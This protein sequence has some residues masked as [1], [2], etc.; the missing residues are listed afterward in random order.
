VIDPNLMGWKLMSGNV[1]E[2]FAQVL[3]L[4]RL[5]EIADVSTVPQI[6]TKHLASLRLPLPPV[7][8]QHAIV[9]ALAERC[10]KIDVLVAKANEVVATLREY[11]AALITDA[12]TGKIDVRAA[13]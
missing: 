12:V 5:E 1:P 7:S 11:R 9:A 2:F 8:E 13:V 4:I 3:K 6:N 10:G